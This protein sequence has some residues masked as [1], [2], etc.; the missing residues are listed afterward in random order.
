MNAIEMYELMRKVPGVNPFAATC[1]SAHETG[2][3]TSKLW[4]EAR[5]G[6][7]LKAGSDWMKAGK[8]FI[9]IQSPEWNGHETVQ[10]RSKFRAYATPGDFAQDYGEKIRTLYPECVKEADNFWGYFSGL[11]KGIWGKWATDPIYFT[12]LG[13][14]A[15]TLAPEL[16]GNGWRGRM[17]LALNLAIDRGTLDD[18]Q[19]K[20]AEKIIK[21]VEAK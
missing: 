4:N 13:K 9:P 8:P 20:A 11:Y 15:V 1:Q 12:K 19:R 16:L 21:E 3:W 5:N 18:Y 6:C 14:M 10:R 17:G 2:R 7:G